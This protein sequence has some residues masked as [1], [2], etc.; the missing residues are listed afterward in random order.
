[1][2]TLATFCKFLEHAIPEE[3]P[4]YRIQVSPLSGVHLHD[5]IKD[6]EREAHRIGGHEPV[7]LVAVTRGDKSFLGIWREV[8]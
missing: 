8:K 3:D 4:E 6:L 7:A 2:N 1:V 5:A